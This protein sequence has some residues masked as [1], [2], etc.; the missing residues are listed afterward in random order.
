M[1]KSAVK[2]KNRKLR[3]QVR[4]TVGALLMASA[5]TVAAI[6]VQEVGAQPLL[7]DADA[8]EK[9]K[10][11]I[12]SKVGSADHTTPGNEDPTNGYANTVPFAQ[13]RSDASEKVVYTSGDGT[14]Q[15]VYIRPTT[16]DVNKVAMI[17]GYNSGVLMESSLT[18]PD[19]L[20]AYR[21]YTDN[22]TREGFCLV[23]RN[24]EFLHYETMVQ[25]KNDDGKTLWNVLNW[26]EDGVTTAK[27]ITEDE[28]YHRPDGSVC[29][30]VQTGTKDDE[31][32]TPIYT[33]YT[34]TEVMVPQYN[35]CYYEQ[36]GIW[37]ELKD[38]DLYY[39]VS[40]STPGPSG[41]GATYLKAGDDS[42][43]WKINAEVAYIGAETL[44][45]D[46]DGGWIVSG[47]V[48]NPGDGVFAGQ[49][50]ITN[51]TIGNNIRGI[52]DYAFYS[53]ATLSSV[54]L[55]NGL[56]TI[57]NGAFAECI[58]LRTVSIAVNAN[59]NAIGK[60]A[61]YDC[62][63]L[64][65][66]SIPTGLQALGDSCFENCTGLQSI[67]LGVESNR[68]VAL[69][70]LGN[71][72]FRGCS[73][74]GSVCFPDSYTENNLNIDMFKGCSS[75]QFI[76]VNNDQL[77]FVD[78]NHN[79]ASAYPKC[80]DSSWENFVN[81]VPASFYFEGPSSSKIHN[82]ATEESIAFKYLGEDLY[83]KIMYEKDVNDPEDETNA[84]VTYQVNS[85]N[86][87]VKFWIDSGDHPENVTIP[88][89][90]GPY[91]ISAIK[92]GS[93]ND[94]CDLIKVT[95]PPSVTSIGD[96]A[97]K[98]CHKLRT[99]IFTDASTMQSIGTDAFKTQEKTCN[100]SLSAPA[101][102]F[103]GAML[104]QGGGDTVPFIYAMN[105]VSN[106]NNNSQSR[107]FI[108]CHSG[109]PTN[110][111]VQYVFDPLT[112]KGEAQL[113]DYLRYDDLL[114]LNEENNEERLKSYV[115][116]KFPYATSSNAK[117]YA[118]ILK[119]AVAYYEYTQDPSKFDSM[120]ERPTEDEM[121]VVTATMNIVIP[122]SVDSIK[123]G[124]FSG[125]DKEGEPVE[126][127][128]ADK[129][130]QTVLINGV[131]EIEPYT[132]KDCTGLIS[133]D[134]IGS[135]YIGDYAFDNCTSLTAATLGT[136]L[137][138][139]GKRP[140]RGCERLTQIYCL[141]SD[142]SYGDGILYRHAGS[143]TEIVQCLET[144]GT[145]NGI[146]SYSAGP[147]EFAGVTSMKDEAFMDCGGIGRV[148]LSSTTVDVIPEAAFKNTPD[149]NTVVL[150]DTVKNIE[151]EA[152]RDSGLRVLTIPGNQA[153]I[154]Q[155]AFAMSAYVESG[156]REDQKRT[157]IFECVAGT[158]ADRYA[159]EAAN[160]YINPEY[161]KV[162]LEHTVYFWDYPDYP[163]T[164]NKALY[165]QVKVKDGEDAVPPETPPVHDGYAF[166]RWTDY[167]NIVRDTDVYP[168]Y[169]S[170]IYAVKFICNVCGLPLGDVQYIE[171]G[172]S[173]V[174]P[175]THEHEG[176][177]FSRWSQEYYNV[178]S[179]MDILALYSDNSGSA[180]RHKVTFYDYN[181]EV[182]DEQMVDH[183]DKARPPANPTRSGW[184]FVGW[185]PA[186]FDN[187]TGDMVIVA[188]YEQL[189]NSGNGNG[190]GSGNG[191][192]NGNG[193]GS[194]GNGSSPAPGA[195]A[196][197][198]AAPD[199]SS[200]E[201]MRLYTVS[202]SG[203]S[204]SGNYAAGAIVVLNAYD[205]GTG[206]SF[207]KWTTSTAGVAFA[208]PNST[209]TTF[210]MPAAN[211][212]VTATYKTG[213]SAVATNVSTGGSGGAGNTG[214]NNNVGGTSV[215]VTRPG[216]SNTGLAGATVSG[217]TDNFIIR[218]TEEQAA[219]DA[220]TAAL[221]A[222]Y[223]DLSRIKYFPMDI[224][225]YDSTGR[226]KIADTSGISV[227]LT[228]PLPDD[229][230]QYA[231]NNRVAAVSGGSLEDLNGRFT[232]VNGVPCVT[233][234]ATHFSPY[235]IYVD[236]AN[237][238]AG[239]I[240]VTPKTGDPIHPKWFLSIGMAC[241]ALILF[242]KRDKVVVKAA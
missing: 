82:T 30:R 51:L 117:E 209:S 128:S 89:S 105:G 25:A 13:D 159:K 83:E 26:Q 93:F 206:Q 58:S 14:F 155:D 152:F 171:E 166:S 57:G 101:L 64:Q 149:L 179:D 219:T 120:P 27:Q 176:Y 242:F 70:V 95:I 65:T 122:S 102:T 225:L 23:S 91:G 180:S 132:F 99:V 200:T 215:E 151:A 104:N 78:D 7:S 142:F 141:D 182:L 103:V 203:G 153:Y 24:G 133:A 18:I 86:E 162:Y 163:D 136:N 188:S 96:N 202:V 164:I 71:H 107:T 218:V 36:R 198:T 194:N 189:A 217:A 61:F 192:G 237:L 195:T 29:Y 92:A 222:R 2:K 94:N 74:L 123:P 178:T 81:T 42:T 186:D 135:T 97:F 168:V 167:T 33:E 40:S 231:G 118:D 76:Q 119:K 67:D 212:S 121:S 201:N 169:G 224:S 161:G 3:R 4:R 236:T 10:V 53:C 239:A 111:E 47:Y 45:D 190:N 199:S 154:A 210:T 130:L 147:D 213:S 79:N 211:V 16:N 54:S 150:P 68:N 9:V 38:Q 145:I 173:A 98:G 80:T 37:S 223:G 72:L 66:F 1:A 214:G 19:T 228:L 127:S 156:N 175:E 41:S 116:S 62:R 124:L 227:S 146:G 52:G 75:L 187:V 32:Q 21:K 20:L 185:V 134:V 69:K 112:Q 88:A 205:M 174:P 60:D 35:P 87:L 113:V 232:T 12:E 8:K 34:V 110:L 193:N 108:V 46:G 43:H 48:T 184:R 50:N 15:F 196:T 49:N 131:S 220:V 221:Q 238:T 230:V 172:R 157:I 6:P 139:T 11:S 28:L 160:W 165:H 140:F 229:L 126:D 56:H 177:S 240:D 73:K 181:G 241:I 138:D 226:T 5:I 84:R 191:S 234:T 39:L 22:T 183:G 106:I 235:V 197:P 144:R 77:N 170:N 100:D 109:W 125:V 31:E 59:L 55:A 148:D 90:I 114:E 143:E 129:Y 63:A 85:M 207:D 115:L 158:T 233:F 204:G 208:N 17:L 44:S 137:V 216:I